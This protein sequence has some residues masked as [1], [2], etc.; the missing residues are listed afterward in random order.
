[1]IN[2]NYYNKEIKN[3]QIFELKD[4]IYSQKKV[5]EDKINRLSNEEIKILTDNWIN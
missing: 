5:I 3:L 2:L 4:V 1:M